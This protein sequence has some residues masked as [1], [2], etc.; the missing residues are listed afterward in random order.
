MNQQ[1]NTDN[2]TPIFIEDLLPAYEHFVASKCKSGQHILTSLTP[3]KCHLWHMAS[4]IPGEAGE[5]FDQVKKYLIYN[6]PITEEQMKE[7]SKEMGDILF[8]IQGLINGLNTSF[9]TRLSLFSIIQENMDKLNARY[10]AGYTDTEA[11]SR[12]DVA[13]TVADNRP[14]EIEEINR[15][16]QTFDPI[17]END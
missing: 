3:E 2:T 11:Q 4:C 17:T 15:Q 12:A 6:K 1:N 13:T 10:K 8:Y 14:V 5:L 9:G 7:V 16:L